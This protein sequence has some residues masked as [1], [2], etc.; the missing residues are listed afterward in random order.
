M[1]RN[2]REMYA[3]LR[4]GRLGNTCP[5]WPSVAD[6]SRDPA[7][8]RFTLF[9]I[10]SE[11]AQNDPRTRMWVPRGE[12][13]AACERFGAD[14]FNISPMVDAVATL[15]ANMNVWESPRGLVVE[16]SEYPTQPSTW[17]DVMRSPRTF[18]GV[19]A[20][21]VLRRHLNANSLDDLRILLDAYPGHVVEISA[22]ETCF[23]TV[24]GRNGVV[25][26]VRNY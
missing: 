20:R 1:I 11:V 3:L 14:A 5:S 7:A 16:A 12:V 17:R 26:E 25:W 13:V 2:K 24:P 4:S 23:G 10:R 6:W 18:E 8:S 21:Y 9:G 22:F 15:T 19:A